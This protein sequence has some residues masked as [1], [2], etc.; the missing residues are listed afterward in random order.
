MSL[1]IVFDIAGDDSAVLL[2][3]ERTIPDA[4]VEHLSGMGGLEI[5]GTIA[6]PTAALVVQII[7]MLKDKAPKETNTTIVQVHI[8]EGDRS[9]TID[10]RDPAPLEPRIKKAVAELR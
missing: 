5:I 7:A 8:Y 3:L 2:E 10:A 9:V 4:R 6:I 1:E